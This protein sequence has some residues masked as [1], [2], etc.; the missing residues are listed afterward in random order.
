MTPVRR[1]KVWHRPPGPPGLLPSGQCTW[2]ARDSRP[3]SRWS[4][5]TPLLA[6]LI[7]CRTKGLVS[8][9][10][11]LSCFHTVLDPFSSTFSCTFFFLHD[12]FDSPQSVLLLFLFPVSQPRWGDFW[13]LL[14]SWKHMPKL[15]ISPTTILLQVIPRAVSLEELVPLSSLQVPGRGHGQWAG[16]SSV[17][18]DAEYQ[19]SPES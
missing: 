9:V 1:L 6:P 17:R 11:A 13:I 4:Q 19:W 8:S 5:S 12:N 14:K 10:K 7:G 3:L 18:R 2:E 16:L 15:L